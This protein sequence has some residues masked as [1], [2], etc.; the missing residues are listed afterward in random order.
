[1]RIIYQD[2]VTKDPNM[3]RKISDV[4]LITPTGEECLSK[5]TH[6]FQICF[7]GNNIEVLFGDDDHTIDIMDQ[8]LMAIVL[9]LCIARMNRLTIEHPK[10]SL[11][12][13]KAEYV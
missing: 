2:E 8:Q 13:L 7:V 4:C 5:A 6:G 10:R 11:E 1:M 3:T 12:V 9:D